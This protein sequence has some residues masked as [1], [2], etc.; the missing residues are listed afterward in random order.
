MSNFLQSKSMLT[1]TKR[2]VCLDDSDD[3][4]ALKPAHR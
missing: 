3:M 4:L 1:A 2:V